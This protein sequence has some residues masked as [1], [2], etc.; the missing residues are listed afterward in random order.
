MAAQQQGQQSDK[1]QRESQKRTQLNRI[2]WIIVA[3][4]FLLIAVGILIWVLTSQASWITI[5]PIVI[6][7]A[8]GVIIALFQWLFPISSSKFEHPLATSPMTPVSLDHPPRSLP[9]RSTHRGIVGLPPPTDPRTIQQRQH[10]V[11]EVFTKLTQ[12]GVT[13]IALTGI[14]GVGKST[15]AALVYRFAEEQ[16]STHNGPCMS[17]ALWLTVDP[18]VTFADL[19]GNLFEA[20]GKLLPDLGNLAPQN[21][22]VALFNALN[23]TENPRLMILDQFENLLDWESGHA[24]ADRPGVGEWLD[25]INSQQCACRILLTSRPHPV[26]TRAFPPTYMQEYAVRGLEVA[27]GVQLLQNQGVKETEKE[28]Q[29]AVERCA[30]HAFS[31]ILLASLIRDHSLDLTTLLKDPTL[32]TGD[33]ATNLLD[34]IYMQQLSEVQR[35]LI[36]AFSAYREPVPLDAA[37]AVFTE[38]SKAQLAPALKA[39]LTE[40]L[41]E[42]HGE[43][44]YQLHAIIANYARSHFD[45]KNEKTNGESLQ[46]AHAKAAQYYMQRA[47]TTCPPR[48]ERR[49]VSDIHD[50]IEAVWQYCQAEK[51]QEAYDLM[52]QAEIFDDLSRWGGNAI[53]LDLHQLL[54][55]IGKWHPERSQEA[56]IYSN[57][58][59]VCRVLGQIGRAREYFDKALAIYI[60]EG[61]RSEEGWALHNL[62]R[63][64]GELGKIRQAGDYYESAFRAFKEAS[65]LAGEGT[66]LND[67]G[68]VCYILG[69]LESA[70]QYYQKA[71]SIRKDIGDRRGEGV[72]LNNLGRIYRILGEKKRAQKYYEQALDIFREEGDLGREGWTLHNLGKVYNDLG[73]HEQAIE[74]LAQALDICREIGDRRGEGATLSAI[75]GV[76]RSLGETERALKYYEQVFRISKEIGDIRG[77]ASSLTAIGMVRSILGQKDQAIKYF[78]QALKIR[79][80]VEDHRGEARTLWYIGI[81]YFEQHRY[82]VA[83]SCFLLD[84]NFLD[85]V[86]SPHR[87]E[88]QRWIEKIHQEVGDEQFTALLAQVEPQ[89][90]QIVDQ[91]LR[92]EVE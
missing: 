85:E 60:E 83:L 50:L 13:A 6:F 77:E 55:P 19:A 22:A 66:A 90:Q 24:L 70:Q 32:W 7:T 80:K 76:Y 30:G 51:W 65:D 47:V 38:T 89:A 63:V 31:L 48:E 36:L 78:K 71:L 64:Y 79:R 69:R 14:G 4:V 73:Q 72:T 33:I 91:A 20:L 39:L 21:Q 34:Q 52:E 53:L 9:A 16:R 40:N 58:G 1:A 5:L 12:P 29:T 2:R 87:D 61:N 46:K 26:G 8:L 57:L 10:V 56:C 68:W 42:A 49:R 44:R 35:E 11:K 62:G 28:L 37:Q 54:L 17:E 27:E 82:Y 3:I 41:L 23:S 25:I 86:Q 67:L 81:F 92:E 84:K 45:E 18:A 59:E 43:G 74:Y 88:T 75:G 15:L